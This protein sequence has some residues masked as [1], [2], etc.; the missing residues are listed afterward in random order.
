MG[1]SAKRTLGRREAKGGDNS[2]ITERMQWKQ[3]AFLG[4]LHN[5]GDGYENFT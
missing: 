4:S 1:V 5:D 3:I 2:S